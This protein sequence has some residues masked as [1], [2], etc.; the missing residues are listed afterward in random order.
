MEINKIYNEDCL[1]VMKNIEDNSIDLIVTDPPY[2]VTS[3]G[4]SSSTTGGMLIKA[5]Y[6]SGKVFEHNDIK[7]IQYIPEFFRILKKDSHCYI[8]INHI[9]LIEMLNVATNCGFHFVK[10]LIWDK[11]NKIMGRYYMSQFEYILFFRKGADKPINNF[12]TSDIIRIPNKKMSNYDDDSNLHDTE[13]PIEL[14]KILIENSTKEGELVFEPFAGIGST[15]L[16]SIKSKR[17]YIGVEIDK[18]YYETILVRIGEI[19]KPMPKVTLFS[20][21]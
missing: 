18:K 4:N 3:R 17:N 12:G 9:N 6:M 2:K 19:E 11:G 5:S 7:P 8:M 20:Y 21:E 13:K 14:I 1:N 16:A 15:I 10:S